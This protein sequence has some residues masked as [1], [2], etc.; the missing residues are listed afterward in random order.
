MFGSL[1]AISHAGISKYMSSGEWKCNK[2]YQY[3][4][5]RW[6]GLCLQ[7]IGVR[8]FIDPRILGDKLCV[9]GVWSCTDGRA[10]YHHYKTLD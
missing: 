9:P 3:G 4:E 5:D 10:A 2:N 7:E 1:E 8:S 6:L